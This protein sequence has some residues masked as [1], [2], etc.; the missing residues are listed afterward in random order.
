VK[1]L[2]HPDWVRRMNLFGETTGD[3]A[4]MVAS[5]LTRS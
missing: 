1:D 5:M 3:P 4:R 2:T